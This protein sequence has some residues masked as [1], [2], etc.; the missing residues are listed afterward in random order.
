[1]NLDTSGMEAALERVGATLILWGPRIAAALAILVITHF[2][3]KLIERG[4]RKIGE[5]SP[6]QKDD[7]RKEANEEIWSQAGKLGYWLIWLFGFLIALQPLQLGSVVAPLNSLLNE[8]GM[9]LPNLIGALAIFIVGIALSKIAKGITENS[10]GMLN[11]D[12][13]LTEEG[14]DPAEQTKA[15]TSVAAAAGTAVQLLVLLPITL[16]A[17]DVLGIAAVTVPLRELLA[18]ILVAVPHVI[19]AALVLVAAFFIGRW[20]AGAAESF[21]SG[22]GVNRTG[23]AIGLSGERFS[24]SRVSYHV[25]L[26]AVMLFAFT[27]AARLLNFEVVSRI[28]DE[29]VRLG[30]RIVFGAAVIAAGFVI[31]R[32]ASKLISENGDAKIGR[33]ASYAIIALT[34]AMGLSFMGIATEIV[35]IAFGAILGAVAI[36]AAIAFGIGGRQ[37]AHEMLQDWKN[38]SNPK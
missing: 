11:I 21:L 8:I 26:I 13:W 2:V 24:I 32:I 4:I 31:A 30:G 15:R 10:V 14:A 35:V 3:A 25:I 33:I 9:F 28:A 29:A 23:S 12:R 1:M 37:T 18:T 17:I 6:W 27:E 22:L 19:A 5:K 34:I 7:T 20:I 16:A 36:A 38:E